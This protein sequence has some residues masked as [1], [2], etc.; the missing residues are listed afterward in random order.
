MEALFASTGWKLF[1]D[2]FQ[3]MKAAIDKGWTSLS[4]D[5]LLREQGRAEAFGQLLNYEEQLAS[6]KKAV[7]DQREAAA[8]MF[9]DNV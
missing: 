4:P 6:G 2:D 9:P 3:G 1:I 5:V 7:I 8:A